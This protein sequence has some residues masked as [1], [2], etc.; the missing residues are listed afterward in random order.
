MYSSGYSQVSKYSSES[1]KKMQY[2]SKG[3]SCGYYMRIVFFFSSLIQSLIIVSLVLF[4]VYGKKQDSTS[5]SRIQDLEESFSRLSI[6]NIALKEQRRNLTNFLN[7]TLTEKTRND[8]DL[9][10]SRD[11][12]N[13][14][15]MIIA[16]LD[17]KL[18]QRTVELMMCRNSQVASPFSGSCA[19]RPNPD[20]NCGLQSERLIAKLQLV[21]SNFTQTVQRMKAGM[22]QI[23]NE[24]DN[25]N[26]ETIRLR[27]TKSTHEKELEILR[28]K[29]KDDF[30]L[31]LS[32]VSNVS[33]AFLQKI[34]TLFPSHI[35]FQLTCQKQRE[36]LEQI[37]TNCTSLSRE[38]E[39]RF[40]RYLNNVGEQVT[41]IQSENSRLKA[42]NWRLSTD[43]RFCSLNR[44]A[45]IQEHRQ[46]F[47][48]L[49]LKHDKDHERL[50]ED[51]L[52]LNGQIEVLGKDINFKNKEVQH[53]TEQIKLL[54]MSCTFK[55]A[56]GGHSVASIPRNPFSNG[57]S[58]SSGLGVLGRTGSGS[59]FS[60]T[61]AGPN[62]PVSTGL[63]SSSFGSVGSIP[64]L[65][66]SGL[67]SNKPA[68]T[69]LGSSSYGSTGSGLGLGIGSN[70]PTSTGSVS[71]S[72]SLSS[73]FGSW[74]GLGSSNT[75]QS[76]PGSGT[77]RGT[78]SGTSNSGTGSVFGSGRTSGLGGGP[79]SVTQHLQDL[80]RLI[81]PSRPEEKQ[82]LSRILG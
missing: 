32:G 57:G 51:K 23:A 49:Q 59:V 18:Q 61:G 74:M 48:K 82:D 1:Q 53:L 42:E 12:S 77:G 73:A 15:F 78:S 4:L 64:N 67:G 46:N 26:L 35:A 39:D 31:S 60:L 6:E 11:L 79:V 28:L 9:V 43:Y 54:N 52:R 72:G 36:H 2:H 44:T 37:R 56:S 10:R 20:C 33:K 63:G 3:K 38:V 30:T 21:E 17:K 8:W 22:D 58:S 41:A 50:L 71:K 27:K 34:E 62:K 40:Q 81:N 47:E 16:D 69:G 75:G 7:K 68:S 19:S 13:I 80:Q 65:S 25:L 55:P 29:C 45:L 24:R 76:K 5:T 66:S 70:K 14:S